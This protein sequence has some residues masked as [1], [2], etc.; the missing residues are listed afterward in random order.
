[1]TATATTTEVGSRI[2][3]GI[4]SDAQRPDGTLKVTGQ[5]AY[6]SDL[7]AEG[8]VWG[9]TLRSPHP[10]ARIRSIN[11]GPAFAID[12]VRA[13]LTADDVPGQKCYGLE[14]DDQPAMTIP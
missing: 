1:M 6:G 11:I 4:G 7:W 3:G 13:V 14:F 8:M 9:V 12:G 10:Y 2:T 5:F